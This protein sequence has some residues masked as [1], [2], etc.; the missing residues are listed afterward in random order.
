MPGEPLGDEEFK[1]DILGSVCS[2]NSWPV[3]NDLLFNYVTLEL[4]AAVDASV[5]LYFKS[6]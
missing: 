1:L 3:T 4:L 5:L 2:I 6:V